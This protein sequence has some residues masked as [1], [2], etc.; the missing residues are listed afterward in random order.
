MRIVEFS[1]ASAISAVSLL[2]S[3]LED[4]VGEGLGPPAGTRF[5]REDR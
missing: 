4:S 5:Y 3:E 1:A 2:A